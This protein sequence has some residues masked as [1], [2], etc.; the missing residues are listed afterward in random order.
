MSC[1][2]AALESPLAA[3]NGARSAAVCASHY[4]LLVDMTNQMLGTNRL[5]ER[6]PLALEVI[7]SGLGYPRA[8]VALI[9]ERNEELRIKSAIGFSD[10]VNLESIRIPIE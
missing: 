5:D 7:T 3:D 8:M 9:D 2:L 10:E 4:S 6:L 1:K